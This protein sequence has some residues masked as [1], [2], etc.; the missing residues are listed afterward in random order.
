MSRLHRHHRG[1]CKKAISL[2]VATTAGAC[3][4]Q[5]SLRAA[6]CWGQ[7]EEQR[8]ATLLAWAEGADP[9]ALPTP[10]R[11]LSGESVAGRFLQLDMAPRTRDRSYASGE[12]WHR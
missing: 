3:G 4:L 5:S 8:L 7:V 10:F 2:P 12:D 1:M 9:L 6:D 11:A